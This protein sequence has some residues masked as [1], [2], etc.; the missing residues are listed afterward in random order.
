[1]QIVM[2]DGR[3]E[4]ER[5]WEESGSQNFDVL[6]LDAFSSDSVPTHLMTREAL[7]L[8]RRHLK[9]DGVILFH[10]TNR[11]LDLRSVTYHLAQDAGLEAILIEHQPDDKFLYHT[12]WVA[13]TNNQPLAARIKQT[14]R[15]INWPANLKKVL[16]TD[17]YSS[18]IPLINWSFSVW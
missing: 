11:F 10:I 16:W 3:M 12:T 14:G 9:P 13:L 1:V 18:L 6:V 15:A 5:Q 4:L 2:G 8:Y 7:E 17:D